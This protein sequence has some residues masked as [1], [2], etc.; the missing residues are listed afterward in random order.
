[1]AKQ[2]T[3]KRKVT[4]KNSRKNITQTNVST[5]Y[6]AHKPSNYGMG[7][8]ANVD[9]PVGTII[10]KE[11]PYYL[12]QSVN[13]DD[14][15]Y[16]FKLI[17]KFLSDKQYVKK[18]LSLVPQKINCT[19]DVGCVSYEDIKYFHKLYLP[20]LSK[21]DMILYYM[22]LKRNMFTFHNTPGIC[23]IATRMNHSCDPNIKY[24]VVGKELV[25]KIKK[26]IQKND[27]LFDSYI[28]YRLPKKERQQ[29]L[30]ERYG[31]MCKCTKCM[32]E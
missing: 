3:Q 19:T 27:E 22:K 30:L 28:D 32:N 25:F 29:I 16:V 2:Y 18:F 20:Y 17:D 7:T 14:P 9:I 15:S 31:F 12:S 8:F 13:E 6:F 26:P 5:K 23:F 10:L 24:D 21:S 4:K 11:K 1:M